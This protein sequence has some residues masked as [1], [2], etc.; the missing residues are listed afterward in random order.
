LLIYFN[1]KEGQAMLLPLN[2]FS[3]QELTIMMEIATR[4]NWKELTERVENE[5][6]E[7]SKVL[8]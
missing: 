4:Y 5:L 7:R 1:G 8:T 2:T 3:E 6:T